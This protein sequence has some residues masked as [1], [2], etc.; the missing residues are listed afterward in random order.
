MNTAVSEKCILLEK[1]RSA[2]KDKFAF[3]EGLMGVIAGF[4]YTSEQAE[5][6]ADKLTEC[7]KILRKQTGIFSDMRATA[8][9]V[10]LSKMALSE[11]PEKYLE[12][13]KEVNEK[14]CGAKLSKGT[15]AILAAVIICDMGMQAE[16]DEAV[17]KA[18]ELMKRMNKD[19]PFL[20]GADDISP[21]V[22]M[23]LSYKETDKLLADLEEGYSYIKKTYK[24]GISSDAVQGVCEILAMSYG[25]MKAKCDKVMRI[26]KVLK[27]KKLDFSTDAKFSVLAALAETDAAPETLAA[28]IADASE[29][30]KTMKGFDKSRMDDK[31]RFMYATLVVADVYGRDSSVAGSTV[32]NNTIS[33]ITAKRNAAIMNL[34]MNIAPT[35]L[36]ACADTAEPEEKQE[37]KSGE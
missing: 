20:T 18:K 6:D 12:D 21:V 28:D 19:H 34:V 8:E 32:I 23:A 24:P 22:L 27:D 16:C 14:I 9:L 35:L 10:I 2:V 33:I 36:G 4:I 7:R 31:E 15:N 11:D 25:D 1:N 30:L 26:Y 29:F 17:G 37:E 5:A 13:I 3:E